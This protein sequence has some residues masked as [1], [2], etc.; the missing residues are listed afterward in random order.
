M[1]QLQCTR[2]PTSIYRLN[3]VTRIA[4]EFNPLEPE[5]GQILAV[6][7][8]PPYAAMVEQVAADAILAYGMHAALT[9]QPQ[10]INDLEVALAKALC[11]SF[12]A[13]AVFDQW[14]G[15]PP[16]ARELDQIVA[17]ILGPMLTGDHM[18]PRQLWAAGFRMFE[19]LNNSQFK[20]SLT[21]RLAAWLRAGWNRVVATETFRLSRPRQTVPA[22]QAALAIPEN[23]ARF[24]AS[25]LL[26][27]SEA[28]AVE[29][30]QTYRDQL[31]ALSQNA[32][33][34][35]RAA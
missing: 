23:D 32:T 34:P 24:I 33:P 31:T 5:R 28:V 21:A 27:A 16:S 2:R 17:D 22:I 4:A 30:P 11:K 13:R 9:S 8:N 26:A 3:E 19:K 14:N 1:L 10:A 35:A 6:S 15:Q 20:Q 12:P 7:R 29:L 18:A 25:L